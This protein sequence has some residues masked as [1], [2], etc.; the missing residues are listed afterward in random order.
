MKYEIIKPTDT[1]ICI[2]EINLNIQNVM[3]GKALTMPLATLRRNCEFKKRYDAYFDW[4]NRERI[5]KEYYEKN[6]DKI[7]EYEKEYYEKN[8]DKIAKQKKEYREKNKDK[9]KEY[10]KVLKEIQ[11][12]VKNSTLNRVRAAFNDLLLRLYKNEKE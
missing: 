1:P 12:K 7:K 2:K 9:I 5:Q 11:G 10:E 4:V 8:K 6:K 3:E